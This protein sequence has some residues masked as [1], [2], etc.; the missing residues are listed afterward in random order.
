MASESIHDEAKELAGKLN[1]LAHCASLI[2]D[3]LAGET[4]S[5]LN[6]EVSPLKE[7]LHRVR[8]YGTPERWI[9]IS[10]ISAALAKVVTGNP[11]ETEDP[12]V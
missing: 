10:A 9:E 12:A 11:S 8:I 6:L 5:D 2:P 4:D 3:I 1:V 7:H